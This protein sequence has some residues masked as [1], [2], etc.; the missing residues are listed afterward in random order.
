VLDWW[1]LGG[2]F[3]WMMGGFGAE[4]R[5]DMRG[6]RASR[7]AIERTKAHVRNILAALGKS[8]AEIERY[9][10]ETERNIRARVR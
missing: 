10:H 2:G 1:L 4:C 9:M 6:A 3:A 7:V 8:P 5:I